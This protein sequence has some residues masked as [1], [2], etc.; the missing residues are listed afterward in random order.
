MDECS[1]IDNRTMEKIVN[2]IKGNSLLILAGD[3]HQ[4]EAIE[5]GNWF[6][7]MQRI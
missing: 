4:I 1:V 5:F 3:I 7:Y 2:K 6:Y